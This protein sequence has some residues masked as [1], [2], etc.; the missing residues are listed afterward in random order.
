MCGLQQRPV[1]NDVLAGT[2]YAHC[3]NAFPIHV[4][5]LTLRR[6]ALGTLLSLLCW[7]LP[8]CVLPHVWDSRQLANGLAKTMKKKTGF[9]YASGLQQKPKTA[10]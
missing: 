6:P 10:V 9:N 7:V 5:T 8:G 3:Y 4:R 1:F 2:A